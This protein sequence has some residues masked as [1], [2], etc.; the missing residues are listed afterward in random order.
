VGAMLADIE[1]AYPP[2]PLN[3]VTHE[4]RIAGSNALLTDLELEDLASL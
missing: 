4:M 3:V 2:V 1:V